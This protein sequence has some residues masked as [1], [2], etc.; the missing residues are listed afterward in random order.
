MTTIKFPSQTDTLSDATEWIAKIDRG[1]S[2]QEEQQLS[3]WLTQSP[4]HGKTLVH[5]ASMWDLLDVLRPIAELLPMSDEHFEDAARTADKTPSGRSSSVGRVAMAASVL[6]SLGALGG[7]LF[8]QMNAVAP[9]NQTAVADVPSEP[10]RIIRHYQTDFGETSL[11]TLADGSVMQLNTNSSVTVEYSSNQRQIELVAG[12]VFFE[13]AKDPHKPFV[14][15]SG[16]D[17]VTAVGT[18]FSVDISSEKSL[19]V[20]VTEGKVTVN[21][22]TGAAA[23]VYPE[24]VLTPGQRV[25]VRDSQPD[26]SVEQ[27]PEASLAWREGFVVFNGEPL[28][29]VVSE[30]DRYTSLTFKITDPELAS[31]PVGGYF[32]TGDLEQLLLVLQQN[33][34]VAHQRNGN[35]ILLSK[36]AK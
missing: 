29:A 32:K 28:S 10:A 20:M 16:D 30:I 2:N 34:G 25:V 18:A 26:V 11:Y 6:V 24:V 15:A 4:A 5:A 7:W 21:R 31:V 1:L 3:E 35:E 22:T 19:E 12:E 17:R 27:D 36:L 9:Q 14:V 23:R 13:V 8:M 33:F